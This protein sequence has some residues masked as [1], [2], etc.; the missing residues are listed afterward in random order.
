VKKGREILV[1]GRMESNKTEKDGQ[2]RIFWGVSVDSFEFCG[3]RQDAA[4]EA[5]T[6]PTSPEDAAAG[7]TGVETEELPF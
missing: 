5:G 6:V 3:N 1:V 4:Q 2:K 7:F